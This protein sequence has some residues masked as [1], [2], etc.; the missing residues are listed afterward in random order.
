MPFH[1]FWAHSY[2]GKRIPIALWCYSRGW[3][4]MSYTCQIAIS[5]PYIYTLC[6][7]TTTF[8]H[9]GV[10]EECNIHLGFTGKALHCQQCLC[11]PRSECIHVSLFPKSP[12][13]AQSR[14]LSLA[15][16]QGTS[17]A[18]P[19]HMIAY[20]CSWGRPGRN[21]GSPHFLPFGQSNGQGELSGSSLDLFWW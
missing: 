21:P 14:C 8:D 7:F 4:G 3:F 16:L 2:C 17:H 20:Q 9:T 11:L 6:A 19:Y 18:V 15:P 12:W 5:G 10:E 1:S 13:G